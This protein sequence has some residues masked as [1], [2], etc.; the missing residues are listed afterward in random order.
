MVCESVKPAVLEN[1]EVLTAITQIPG[2]L[3]AKTAA[4]GGERGKAKP[5]NRSSSGLQLWH[6]L[7]RGMEQRQPLTLSALQSVWVWMRDRCCGHSRGQEKDCPERATRAPLFLI[8]SGLQQGQ[9][10][11]W[12]FSISAQWVHNDEEASVCICGSLYG[13]ECVCVIPYYIC[14]PNP[15]Q[16]KS[17]FFSI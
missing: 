3:Q 5:A 15:R 7:G 1:S 6:L 13:S 2:P 10:S 14:T 16:K 4:L 12:H 8:L 17:S 9:E 11:C